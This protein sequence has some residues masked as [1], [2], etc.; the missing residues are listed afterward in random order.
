[1]RQHIEIENDRA[2]WNRIEELILAQSCASASAL[3][4]ASG[5]GK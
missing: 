1:M 2:V 3:P 5:S 4:V